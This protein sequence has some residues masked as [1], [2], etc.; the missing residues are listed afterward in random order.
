[1]MVVWLFQMRAPGHFHLDL[2]RYQ[3]FEDGRSVHVERQPMELLILLVGRRGELVTRPEIAA[4]LW[5]DGVFVDVDQ[6]INRIVRKLRLA[7]HED[8]EAPRFVETVVGKGYRFVGPIDVTTQAESGSA[9]RQPEPRRDHL[10][11]STAAVHEP[12]TAAR[13]SARS[14]RWLLSWVSW[15]AILAIAGGVGA[16]WYRFRAPAASARSIAVLPFANL[17]GDAGQDYFADG[18]TDELT[19]DLAKIASLTVISRTSAVHYR[20]TRETAPQVGRELKVGAIIEGSVV[21]AGDRVRITAQLTD[22]STGR[23]LWADSYERSLGDILGAQSVVALE[24]ARQ[25]RTR[26]TPT[27]QDRLSRRRSVNVAAYD[28]YLHG[29][30]LLTTQSPDSLQAGLAAFR[31]SIRLDPTYAPAYAGLAD[32]FSLLADYGVL[33][34]GVAFP[35]AEA[36]AIQSLKLDGSLSDAHVSLA[37]ARHHFDWDWAGAEREYRTAIRLSPSNVT[38]HLRFAEYLFTMARGDEALAEIRRAAELD[39][40]SPLIASNVGRVLYFARRYDEAIQQERA[41]LAVDPSR[42]Y[43]RVY[44]AM[45]LEQERQLAEAQA[46][47][48]AITAGGPPRVGYALFYASAG[49]ATDAIRVLSRLT[50]QGDDSDWFFFSAVFALIGDR[51]RAFECLERAYERHDF[52]LP[53]LRVMPQLDGL[54]SDPRYARLIARLKMPAA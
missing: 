38:A 12:V 43:A 54:R 32:S 24:I 1:M 29:Q 10:A 4:K 21:R 25:V 23:L 49:R 2:A 51:G 16:I 18:V 30:Y 33:A 50:Q 47:L 8:P 42:L 31:E 26:L 17:S 3:L 35:Q 6:S 39:P 48:D 13:G 46:Q 34:P 19:T 20:D 7:F 44:L 11:P 5:G 40:L 14:D 41:V 9:R 36:A 28:A 37:F 27:D 52:F 45:A 22:V 53:Y 15:V